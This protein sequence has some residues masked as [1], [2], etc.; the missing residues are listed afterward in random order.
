[1]CLLV[2]QDWSTHST[3]IHRKKTVVS[4]QL[5]NTAHKNMLIVIGFNFSVINRSGMSITMWVAQWPK[6]RKKHI[7][8]IIKSSESIE[9]EPSKNY[10]HLA[11]C[12]DQIIDVIKL[13]FLWESWNLR[14]VAIWY[15]RAPIRHLNDS[16]LTHQMAQRDQKTPILKYDCFVIMS[17][18]CSHFGRGHW[19]YSSSVGIEKRERRKKARSNKSLLLKWHFI[20]FSFI[21]SPA[22]Y[23]AGRMFFFSLD[24]ARLMTVA[25]SEQVD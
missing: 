19:N 14:V 18:H 13:I 9:V 25:A 2:H 24:W 3:V 7:R 16:R 23:M 21:F 6:E 1:M 22:K 8:I 5:T 4:V 12:T 17:V 15:C 20:R 10:T 11:V